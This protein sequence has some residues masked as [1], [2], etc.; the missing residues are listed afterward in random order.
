MKRLKNYLLIIGIIMT[1]INVASVSAQLPDFR[2]ALIDSTYYGVKNLN[3]TAPVLFMYFSPSCDECHKMTSAILYH[4]E[5]L[6]NIQIV[7]I[8]NESLI[9]VRKFVIRFRLDKY[10]NMIV[11]TEGYTNRFL[12]KF[13][14]GKLPFLVFYD[15]KG[16]F[17]MTYND[18]IPVKNFVLDVLKSSNQ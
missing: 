17:I 10:K 4:I 6:K 13:Q 3:K 16:K 7:M 14:V 11:G 8:T 2:I 9:E 5:D 15:K 12:K 18:T 1:L